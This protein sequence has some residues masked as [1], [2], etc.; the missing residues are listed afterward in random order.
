MTEEEWLNICKMY[1]LPPP[2]LASEE[3]FHGKISLGFFYHSQEESF[4][5]VVDQN[6][7]TVRDSAAIYQLTTYIYFLELTCN[8]I[9]LARDC[10]R[11]KISSGF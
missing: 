1:N 6:L 2:V 11:N 9:P 7:G 3:N 8:S 5:R 4:H 10:N